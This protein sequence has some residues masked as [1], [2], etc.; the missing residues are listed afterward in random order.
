MRAHVQAQ[1]AAAR[2]A[3]IAGTWGG[4]PNEEPPTPRCVFFFFGG[5]LCRLF[6]LL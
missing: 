5:L 2:V 3:G 1:L 6:S 4:I